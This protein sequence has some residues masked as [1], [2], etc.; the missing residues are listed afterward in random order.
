[1]SVQQRVAITL[2]ILATSCEYRIVAHLFGLARCTVCCIVKDTCRSIVK[3]LL[4]KYISFPTGSK[5]SE[6]V[7]GFKTKWGIP[8]CA[9]STDDS[10]IHIRPPAMNHTDYYNCKGFYS[11]IVQAVADHNGLFIGLC[12][13]WPGCVHDARVL[14]NS[15]IYQKCNRGELL[16]GQTFCINSTQIPNFLVGDS[17]YLL[18]P[19]LIKP[20]A[21]SPSLSAQEKVY[22][23]RICRCHVVVEVAFGC[24]KVRWRRLTKKNEMS[25]KNVPNVIAACCTLHNICEIHGDTFNEVWLEEINNETDDPT[26]AQASSSSHDDAE[27]IRDAFVQYF[28]QNPL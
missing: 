2:W 25:I 10:H 3:V 17:A 22:N 9:G 8:Q 13:G 12:I 6:T 21:H 19:W 11:M 4:P 15:S 16:N 20:F 1:M 5:L 14:A 26:G 27:D 24:L 23:Y 18:L 28:V 7:G